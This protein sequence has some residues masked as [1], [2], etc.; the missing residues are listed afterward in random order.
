[1]CLAEAIKVR[2]VR[3]AIHINLDYKIE[4]LLR[5]CVCVVHH[6]GNILKYNISEV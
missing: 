4:S 3:E 2:E 6:K 1:M 5:V